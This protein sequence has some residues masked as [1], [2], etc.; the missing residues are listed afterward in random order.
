MLIILIGLPGC[1]EF[2]EHF[3]LSLSDCPACLAG[4]RVTCSMGRRFGG[5]SAC[6]AARLM[7]GAGHP[8]G[9]Q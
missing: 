2:L 6:V 8:L 3:G 4:A 1:E 5:P 9:R 7:A